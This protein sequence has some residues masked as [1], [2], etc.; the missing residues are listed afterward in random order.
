LSLFGQALLFARS[1]T[2][3]SVATTAQSAVVA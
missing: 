2:V 1:A 3:A